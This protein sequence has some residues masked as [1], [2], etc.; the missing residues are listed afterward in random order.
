[1]KRPLV[2]LAAGYVLGEVLA[3]QD[4]TAVDLG[5]LAW[6]CAAAAGILWLLDTGWGVLRPSAPKEK[7]QGRSNRKHRVLLLFLVCLLSGS[8]LGM[9]RGWQEKGFLDH[10][11]SVARTMAGARILVRGVIKKAEQKEDTVTLVLEEVTAEA[12]RRTGKFRRMVV[13]A[14]NRTT[15]KNDSD[16]GGE[17][18]V[19]VKVQVRGKLA[20]VEGPGNPGEFDF[21]TYYRTKGIACRLYGENLAV[22]GGEAIPYYKG[23]AEFRMQCAGV[24]EKICMPED[25]AVFK[26]VLLGDTSDMNPEMRDMY[27]RNGISHLL[28]V[29]GQ[30]LAIIGGGI[31]LMIRRAGAG[32]GKAGMISAV[33]VISYGIMT[34]SSGSAI[35]AVIMIVCLWLA[36]VKGRS[37]DTLSALGAAA[38]ILLYRQPYLLY[39]SG[40][41]LSFGAVLA[42]SGLGGWVQSFLELERA[43]EKTLLISL[44]VQIVLTPIV[45]YHYFQHP[46]YG[47]FLNLL[48]IPLVSIL[49][50][51]GILGIVLGSFWIQGG[52]AAVGA[53]HYILRFYELLCE[54]AEGLPGYSLV[55]GRPSPGSLV[56][57]FGI[58]AMGTAVVLFC[59]RGRSAFI[60]AKSPARCNDH[61]TVSH[62]RT[63]VSSISCKPMILLYFFGIYALSFAALVP[64]PV[65]GLEV[66]CLDVG[67]GDGLLLRSGKRAVLIDG[68]SSSQKKLGDIVLEPYLKSRGI[69]WIDYAVVSHGDSDHINGLM[70]LL[71]Q[72]KDIGIGTLVLPVMGKGEEVYENLAALARR[73]GADVVYM[74]TGDWVETGELTLTCL[75]AGEDFG[76]KDRNSHSLVLCGDYKGFHMLFTGDMGEGQESS[77]VRL[78]EQEGTLQDIHLNH[79]QILKT[80]HHGS[81]TSSSEVFLDRLRIQLAVVSYGK[82]NSYGHPSPETM[83]RFRRQGISVLETG[84]KGAITLKTDGTSLRVHAF[85][86]EK[87]RQN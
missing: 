33:L 61:L 22:A 68:G 75:Y 1:M 83:G 49:M 85:L 40:F 52:V 11:E 86:E 9:A 46:L 42:I 59:I 71:E 32:Y 78:A 3:L 87:S 84:K 45:L 16:S 28:A 25:V 34:G 35:R 58:H 53:G 21:R 64:R 2:V 8:S 48:V 39:H 62:F 55:L 77:L 20:P 24:L 27:Q 17:L 63:R 14:E 13:Y 15:E 37:Y 60:R 79:V 41:E 43:W 12:G 10:E 6:L 70:Y 29:S 7:M 76:G 18:A 56:M 57:Y 44:S 66:V 51:S 72:S 81:R 23:I 73:E 19:G 26:A 5:V 30:H 67:Q 69:S 65:K 74:K 47:I 4:N 38:L 31:Y 50:Y 82:E 80:A 54:F 36:A